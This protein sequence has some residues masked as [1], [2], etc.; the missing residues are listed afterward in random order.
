MSS[1]FLNPSVTPVHRV[2]HQAPRQ[3]VELLQLRVVALELRHQR[4]AVLARTGRPAARPD[5]ACPSGPCTSTASA[6]ILT[7]TPFGS[8]IGFFPIRDIVLSSRPACEPLYHTL[9]STSPPTP[10]FLA[11]RPVITPRDVVRML[12]PRPP[13]TVG[14][15]STPRYTRR[16]GRLIRSMPGDDL[17]ALGAVLQEHANDLLRGCRRASPPASRPAETPG[18]SP[19]PAGCARSPPSACW[20]ACPHARAWPQPRCGCA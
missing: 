1:S 5:A 16:P 8:A 14:T 20:R 13:S 12:V 10:A 11:A 19:R 18:C 17:L 3:P 2:G 6:A 7:V 4:V 15:S 9:Q